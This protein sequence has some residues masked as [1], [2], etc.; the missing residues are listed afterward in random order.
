[1]LKHFLLFSFS[2][3]TKFQTKFVSVF[4]LL[5]GGMDILKHIDYGTAFISRSQSLNRIVGPPT[6]ST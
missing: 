6:M 1:M 2:E 5:M 3:V 4:D